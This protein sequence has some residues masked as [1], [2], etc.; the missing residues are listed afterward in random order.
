MPPVWGIIIKAMTLNFDLKA[1]EIVLWGSPLPWKRA[2]AAVLNGSRKILFYD[3]QKG[4][5]ERIRKQI[6]EKINQIKSNSNYTLSNESLH[7]SFIFLLPISDRAPERARNAKLWNL[8]PA[9]HKPDLDNLEK[10]YL[11]C[12]KGLLWQ[13]DKQIVSMESKKRYDKNSRTIIRIV[14]KK[15]LNM[16]G[17]IKQIFEILPPQRMKEFA[18]YVQKLSI[19]NEEEIEKNMECDNG[20]ER[21]RWMASVASLLIAFAQSFHGDFTKIKK[22]KR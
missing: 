19:L 22:I 3:A 21:R 14:A 15:D 9:N 18:E 5:K 8:A 20:G 17:D 1:F 2:R 12:A 7:V 10:F 16:D 11:D 4:E 6:W 13:D